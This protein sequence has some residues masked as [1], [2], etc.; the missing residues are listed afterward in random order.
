MTDKQYELT[1]LV[2]MSMFIMSY[3]DETK[4]IVGDACRMLGVNPND[5]IRRQTEDL[6]EAAHYLEEKNEK[7]EAI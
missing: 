2:M 4:K 3:P 6:F 7:K 5:F 1:S